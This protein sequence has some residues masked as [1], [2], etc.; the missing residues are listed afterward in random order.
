MPTDNLTYFLIGGGIG[1]I[2]AVLGACI[3]YFAGQRRSNPEADELPGCMFIAA[4]FLGF[5]GLVAVVLSLLFW[6]TLRVAAFA[7]L[8]VLAGFFVGFA[9]LFIGAVLWPSKNR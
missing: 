1:L 7:G 4:G 2:S 5:A 8:G 6:G 9:T 3:D